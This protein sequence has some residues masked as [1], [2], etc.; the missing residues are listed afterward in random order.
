V[1]L[2]APRPWQIR[3]WP[4]D[5]DARLLVFLDHL[6]VPTADD[7]AEAAAEAAAG[8]AVV[9]RTSA[10][11]PRA[12]DVAIEQGFEVIDRLALLRIGLDD[13]FDRFVDARLGASRPRTAP[14]RTWQHRRAAA[15]DR[16][17]FGALWG[18]DAASIREVRRATPV[19]RARQVRRGRRMAGFAI[20]GAAADS[21]YVQRVA[22]DRR[23]RRE[24][25]ARTLVLD[26][27]VW[28]RRRAL[29]CAYVNT[30]VDNHAALALYD[31]L[32]FVRMDEHLLIAER[33]LHPS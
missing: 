27:L 20:S 30:G 12:A 4:N 8:G 18:N 19:H 26:S 17:A 1:V 32:G 21:G 5:P 10:L 31:D 13:R 2:R 29:S 28:M 24:G 14:L 22:V 7:L 6:T 15:V 3:P 11:F 33:R 9:L 23:H 25:I 16:D